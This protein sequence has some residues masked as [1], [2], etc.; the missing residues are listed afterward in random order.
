L[1]NLSIQI[2]F[3]SVCMD[4]SSFALCEITFLARFYSRDLILEMV[5]FRYI[6]LIVFICT[7]LT[8]CYSFLLFYYDFC[9]DFNL[10]SFTE[11]V[12]IIPICYVARLV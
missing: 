6:N 11:L 2:P 8:V 1:G 12:M 10:S 5:S 9:G 7:E 4:V 3:A